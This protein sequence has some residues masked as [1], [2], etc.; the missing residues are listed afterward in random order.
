MN[1]PLTFWRFAAD[2]DD[3]IHRE[4]II[5]FREVYNKLLFDGPSYFMPQT[6]RRFGD[7]ISVH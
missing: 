3:V 4:A 7:L 2:D 1:R 5:N 6:N